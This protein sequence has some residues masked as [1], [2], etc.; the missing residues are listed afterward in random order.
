MTTLPKIKAALWDYK[1]YAAIPF[2]GRHEIIDGS[3]TCI[4]PNLYH[5]EVPRHSVPALHKL[6]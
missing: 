2:D 1:A 6:N 3:T 5:Q 4:Q